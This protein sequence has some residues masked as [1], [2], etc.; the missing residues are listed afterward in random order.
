VQFG[1]RPLKRVVQRY[2]SDPLAQKILAAEISSGDTV[3]IDCDDK[4]Q[5]IFKVESPDNNS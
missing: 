4:G 3:I 1:A 5:V 2:V